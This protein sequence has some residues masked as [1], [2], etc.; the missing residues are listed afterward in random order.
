MCGIAG[1]IGKNE[2]WKQDITN[3]CSRMAHRGPDAEGFWSDD[4]TAVVLGHRRLSILD[5][6]EN[7]KQPMVSHSGRYV[8][9]FNGEI[10][11]YN[12]LA[13]ELCTGAITVNFKT[14]TDTEILIEAIDKWGIKET[15]KKTRGMFAFALFDRK[16]K[17]L[18]L[19]RD[20]MGEKPLYYGKC[21][22]RFVFASELACMEK[23]VDFNNEIC[24]EA[25]KLYFQHGY[26]PAPYSIF[27]NIY[28]L[29]PGTIVAIKESEQSIQTD[30][31]WSMEEVAL[32]GKQNLFQGTEDEAAEELKKL[33]KKA[34]SMQML[35]DV[36]VGAFLSAG[37]D[38]STIVSLMQDLS[39][40]PVK[41]FTIGMQAEQYNE[42]VIAKEIAKILG[43]DHTELYISERDAQ[44]V[45][46]QLSYYYSEPFADSSQIP[47]M[48]VSRLAKEQV[49]VALS[50]DGGDELFAGYSSYFYVENVWKQI[51]G[52]PKCLRGLGGWTARNIPLFNKTAFA[53]KGKVLGCKSPERLYDWARTR[54]Y[55]KKIFKKDIVAYSK[56]DLCE[57]WILDEPQENVML[58][59]L[60][61]YHPD[62]ILVKVDRAAMACSLETRIP[63]LD[64]DVIEFTWSLPFRYKKS[65]NIT[66]RVLKDIL[67][68][69]VPQELMNRP[70]TGFSIPID[71]WLRQGRLKEW[72]EDVLSS[73]SVIKQDIFNYQEIWK[74]WDNFMR[75]DVWTYNI[76]YL[77]MFLEW[78]NSVK[79]S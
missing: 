74:M 26:I 39:N 59:D 12:L 46:P 44:E 18:Y 15:L 66:K 2:Q 62:D 16:D 76:W 8:I 4:N 38:S 20:R 79:K 48:L 30:T 55:N 78:E 28:K 52:F 53:E 57:S 1:F 6:S 9:S 33:L 29:E 67:Y 3:M 70:K 41:T 68:Q 65:E 73:L 25:L 24:L 13:K 22:T 7:G 56:N 42:A 10:Y 51:G 19:T 21:G 64:A 54:E 43:T 11:N 60:Q 72:G 27:K 77:L 23:L 50:G 69:Y 45:I 5:L 31:Y 34:I 35:A 47:T 14:K 63:M 40:I 17:I 32:K 37:I 75:N 49:T 36:P 58:M 61:M 71:K